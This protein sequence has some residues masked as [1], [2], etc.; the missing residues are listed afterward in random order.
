[1]SVRTFTGTA[2]HATEA[3]ALAAEAADAWLRESGVRVAQVDTAYAQDLSLGLW[4]FTITLVM[5]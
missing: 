5:A 4:T 2:R 1:M 3:A